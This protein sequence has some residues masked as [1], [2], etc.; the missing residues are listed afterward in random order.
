[1]D[2]YK[3]NINDVIRKL[4]SNRN[5]G[6]KSSEIAYRQNKYGKNEIK[7]KKKKSLLSMFLEQFDDFLVLILLI[8]ADISIITSLLNNESFTDGIIILVIIFLNAILGII[9]EQKAN[10]ALQALKKLSSPNA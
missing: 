7:E 1:M 5:E 10:N 8:A 2:Y 9:Q 4:E 6:L 3:S